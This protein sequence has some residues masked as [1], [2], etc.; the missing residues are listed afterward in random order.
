VSF[1]D[2]CASLLSK[3]MASAARAPHPDQGGQFGGAGASVTWDDANVAALGWAICYL[4][5]KN[6]YQAL[7]YGGR[8]DSFADHP[9]IH[10]DRKTHQVV[11]NWR[12][13]PPYSTTSAAGRWQITETTFDGVHKRFPDRVTDFAPATQ[14]F[15]GQVLIQDAGALELARAGHLRDAIARLSGTWES[16]QKNSYERVEQ[17]YQ[18]AGGKV[19]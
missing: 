14:D 9:R 5:S 16:L 19:A 10:K 8:F 12:S 17:L 6:D 15:I 11:P 2:L 7:V 4:E 3:L 1:L 13:A 18:Q